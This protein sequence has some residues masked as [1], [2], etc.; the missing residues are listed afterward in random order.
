MLHSG[1][2]RPPKKGDYV[3]YQIS[4]WFDSDGEPHEFVWACSE[5]YNYEMDG[6]NVDMLTGR[7]YEVFPDAWA[8]LPTVDEIKKIKEGE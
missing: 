6:W 5:T 7:K 4:V 8:E 2:E 3:C 1:K